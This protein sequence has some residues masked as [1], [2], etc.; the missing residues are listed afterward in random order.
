MRQ[1]PLPS[2]PPARVA[3]PK[4]SAGWAR[5]RKRLPNNSGHAKGFVVTKV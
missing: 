2:M 1:N 5:K 3:R 4:R